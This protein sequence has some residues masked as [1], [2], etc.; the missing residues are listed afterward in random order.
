MSKTFR[1]VFV[2]NP[3]LCILPLQAGWGHVSLNAHNKANGHP[4]EQPT[5]E[6]GVWRCGWLVVDRPGLRRLI[7]ELEI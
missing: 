5:G 4:E 3:A 2:H 7:P 6:E 1:M